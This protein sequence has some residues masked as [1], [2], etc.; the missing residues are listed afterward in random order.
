MP[1]R[2]ASDAKARARALTRVRRLRYF[3]LRIREG[4]VEVACRG[5]RPPGPGA[6]LSLRWLPALGWMAL[7]FLLSSQRGLRITRT[8]TWTDH[9]GASPTWP[10]SQCWLALLVFA[11]AGSRPTV[12]RPRWPWPSA[13][14]FALSDE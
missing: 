2:R 6:G 8:P 3:P 12:A 13:A 7:L 11:L 9:S 1:G 14:L 4:R 10:A 5:E